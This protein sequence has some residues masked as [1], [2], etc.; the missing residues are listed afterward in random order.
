M[1]HCQRLLDTKDK[2]KEK[3]DEFLFRMSRFRNKENLQRK[4]ETDEQRRQVRQII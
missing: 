1:G 4:N 3:I 2:E